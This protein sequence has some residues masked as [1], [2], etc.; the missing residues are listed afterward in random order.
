MCRL[1]F[2]AEI[3]RSQELLYVTAPFSK[4]SLTRQLST[5][6]NQNQSNDE[7]LRKTHS[8]VRKVYETICTQVPSIFQRGFMTDGVH[9][10]AGVV[11]A[12][13]HTAVEG[14]DCST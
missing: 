1:R 7:Q 2:G 13:S 4:S 12:A 9:A 11:A 5:Q 14:S 8:A 10:R 3:R 6:K